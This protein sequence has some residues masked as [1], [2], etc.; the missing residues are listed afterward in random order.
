MKEKGENLSLHWR[1]V[2]LAVAESFVLWITCLP[3]V[4]SLPP[5]TAITI[6]Q[7]STALSFSCVNTPLHPHGNTGTSWQLKTAPLL[8][9]TTLH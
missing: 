5:Q 4:F 1:Q 8:F 7:I 6:S 3:V 9:L 2:P